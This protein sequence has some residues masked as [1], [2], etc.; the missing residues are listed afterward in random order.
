MCGRQHEIIRMIRAAHEWAAGDVGEAHGLGGFFVRG[1][2][3]GVDELH[4]R[5]M[6]FGGLEVLAEGE[7]VAADGAKVGDRLVQFGFRFAEAEHESGLGENFW[8]ALFHFIQ[9]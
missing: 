5:Q 7:E 8:G 3:V 6:F 2:L 4:H 9:N 1:K